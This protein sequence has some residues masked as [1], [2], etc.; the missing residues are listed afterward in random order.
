MKNWAARSMQHELQEAWQTIHHCLSVQAPEVLHHLQPGA[1]EEQF[2][3]AEVNLQVVL[4]E[5]VKALYR[6][7]NGCVN[8]Y[9]FPDGS[10]K[11]V[12]EPYERDTSELFLDWWS[13]HSLDA[14]CSEWEVLGS[15]GYPAMK[16]WPA[17]DYFLVHEVREWSA[18]FLAQA[19][20]YPLHWHHC[21]LP[22]MTGPGSYCIDLM[23]GP[24][25]NVGQILFV[26]P[27]PTRNDIAHLVAP[28]LSVFFRD[29]AT[30][31]LAGRY[32]F[33]DATGLFLSE[34]GR[35][36]MRTWDPSEVKSLWQARKAYTGRN[37]LP[38]PEDVPLK[39]GAEQLACEDRR[40]M[41]N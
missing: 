33:D 39:G 2:H 36:L 19:A 4:P 9:L 6:L 24:R 18:Q 32:V 30:S 35:G 14:L 41:S 10:F 23:P 38:P 31:L 37:D 22:F 16:G 17:M 3:Q 27:I 29:I 1:T 5:E 21:W 25:G 28:S 34:E 11:E 13:F 40:G 15:E 8:P 7:H 12:V 26:P 20:F